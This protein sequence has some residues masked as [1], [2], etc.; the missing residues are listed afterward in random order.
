MA[1]AVCK[2]VCKS[3]LYLVRRAIPRNGTSTRPGV[4][5]LPPRFPIFGAFGE[6]SPGWQGEM[7]VSR[8]GGP[9]DS[10][11][12]PP[13]ITRGNPG[14]FE[15]QAGI[16]QS[17][18]FRKPVFLRSTEADSSYTWCSQALRRSHELTG[19]KKLAF[20]GCLPS[21]NTPI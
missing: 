10:T 3:V 5:R 4:G 17:G 14:L 7:G 21:K 15:L 20:R 12:W 16:P 13:P 2:L 9:R 18:L 19:S 8:G 11:G 1:S 6:R